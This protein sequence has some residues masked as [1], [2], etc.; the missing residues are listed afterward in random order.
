MV[1]TMLKLLGAALLMVV[2]VVLMYLL[3]RKTAFGRLNRTLRQIVIGVLFGG[4]AVLGTEFGVT[5][6]GATLNVRDAAP[7]CAGLIFGAPAGIIAGIIGGV[8]RWFA[9]YW[10]AGAYTRLACSLATVLAGVFGAALRV[11]MLDDKK[12][13]WF[14]GLLAGL[15]TEVL[16]MLMIF[17]T[18]MS[19]VRTAFTIVKICAAPM[20]AANGL[21]VMLAVLCV[22]LLGREKLA[23]KP[24]KRKIAQTFQRWLLICVLVAFGCTCAFTFF[25]QARLATNDAYKLLKLNIDDVC[26]D[27]QDASDENLLMLARTV[28][29]EL[30]Q[31]GDESTEA[32][33]TLADRYS[34]AEINVIGADGLI[35]ASTNPGFIGFDMASGE[36]SAEFLPLLSGEDAVVQSYQPIAY[37]ASIS[38]KYA[39][40]PIDGGTR[41][42]QLG[43]DAEQFQRDIDQQVVGIT[44]NRHVGESGYVLICDRSL[45]VISDRKGHAGL[46]PQQT[47]LAVDASYAPGDRIR[48]DIYGEKSLCMYEMSEGYYII[49]VIPQDEAM[50]SRDVSVYVTAFMEVVVFAAVF[51]SIYFLIKKII[52]DNIRQIN[53]ALAKIT[54]GNLDV[55]VDVRSNEEFASL[56]N[57][58]NATVDTLKRYIAEAAARIDKE[59]EFAKSIQHSALPS[60][61]PP[62]PNRTEFDIYAMMATAK[63]VGGDF[64]D[65]YLLGEDRL[66][67]LIADVSGKGIPAAMFMMTA[68]TM[69]KSLAETGLGVAEVFTRTNEKLCESNDAGM[70]VT[71]WMGILEL[72]TGRVVFANAGHNP[73]LLKS[74]DGDYTYLKTRPG[75]VLAGMEGVT[76]REQ[77]LRLSPGDTLYLYTD[78]VTE[79]T[80]ASNALYGDDRLRAVLNANPSAD[81]ASMTALVQSDVDAFVGDAPQFDDITMLALKY[82]GGTAQ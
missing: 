21:A 65:F 13:S 44:R 70:F 35:C 62:Y 26:G 68:K 45:T 23:Q 52:V 81:V 46:T 77:E 63:E 28:A 20:I 69:L 67:F 59:L 47:G 22:S 40:V 80:D 17:L 32:L 75:F 37:D 12:P 58:I 72:H 82:R 57:D 42:I 19:D 34:I 56:S 79:A 5:A 71:A 61:F 50:F 27:I 18:N 14:Y 49:A 6:S 16:H 4:L 78:G 33:R 10:G 38:R 41:F 51:A 76:Y 15:V 8:E 48:A 1:A 43:Y 9:V 2:A 54:G 39:G 29:R 3:E 25:L 60:V 64:Y 73:P 66:A 74:G 11:H 55:T 53:G 30:E 36:Q 31:S 7:L 24:H